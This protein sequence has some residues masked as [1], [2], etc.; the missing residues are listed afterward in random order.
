LIKIIDDR[1]QWREPMS[2][3]VSL[4]IAAAIAISITPSAKVLAQDLSSYPLPPKNPVRDQFGVN[5][6]SAT[7]TYEQKERLHSSIDSDL[8]F[9]LLAGDGKMS[10]GSSLQAY[11]SG[12]TGTYQ[13]YYNVVIGHKNFSFLHTNGT[14]IWSDSSGTGNTLT[15]DTINSR[16]TFTN[17]EGVKYIFDTA[18]F[19][20]QPAGAFASCA[21]GRPPAG[22]HVCAA[23]TSAIFPDGKTITFEYDT[24]AVFFQGTTYSTYARLRAAHSSN[25][26]SVMLGYSGW[27]S[28]NSAK[29]IND[30]FELCNYTERTCTSN[31]NWPV[32]AYS[33]IQTTLS[34]GKSGVKLTTQDLQG[35]QFLYETANYAAE[36][37]AYKAGVGVP[38]AIN[39]LNDQGPAGGKGE[40]NPPDFINYTGSDGIK[41]SYRYVEDS[42]SNGLEIRGTRTSADGRVYSFVGNRKIPRSDV[43]VNETDEMGGVKRF[44]YD[45]QLRTV[46]IDFPEANS[47]FYTY[48]QNGNVTTF[49]RRPKP[50]SGLTDLVD[51]ALYPS[52]CSGPLLCNKPISVTDAL[53]NISTYVWDQNTGNILTRTLPPSANGT[54]P[55]ERFTY[56]NRYAWVSNG[57]GGFVQSAYPRSMLVEKRSCI[58]TATSGNSC[59]AGGTDEVVTAYDYGPQSAPN[60]LLLR[61]KSITSGGVTLLECY[62]YDRLGNKTSVTKPN[63]NVQVC[64]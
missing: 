7:W 9:Y 54:H 24:S 23:A 35:N 49:R 52:P 13:S 59:G 19:N 11:V 21:V 51:T 6:L 38:V 28:L 16:F 22:P 8:D 42:N 4:R 31:Y 3:S 1:A 27:F 48:D 26:I 17:R 61:G 53:G 2:K 60:N 12:D 44:F 37:T 20:S 5:I 32:I 63:A 41:Y 45:A 58:S 43:V 57:T 50:A 47:E 15:F 40:G 18:I 33:Q 62:R 34:S 14:G 10:W 46:E 25:G 64:P 30:S 56:A 29:M 55:V 39:F 36:F